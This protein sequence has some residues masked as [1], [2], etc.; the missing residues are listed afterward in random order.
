[1][2]I[3]IILGEELKGELCSSMCASKVYRKDILVF[4]SS[5]MSCAMSED[6]NY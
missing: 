3:D 1:M 6:S 4:D 2:K 5:T